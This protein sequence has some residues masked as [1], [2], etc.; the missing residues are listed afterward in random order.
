M[1]GANVVGLVPRL[2]RP[3]IRRASIA[4]AVALLVAGTVW[5]IM[6]GDREN[7]REQQACKARGGAMVQ[8]GT[9]LQPAGKGVFVPVPEYTCKTK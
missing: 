5:L 6:L 2:A 1:D 4:L 7:D 8:T 9:R 3:V